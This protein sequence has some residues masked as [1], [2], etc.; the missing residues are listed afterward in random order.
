VRR[1]GGPTT[2]GRALFVLLALGIT[3]LIIPTT[4]VSMSMPV[5]SP[6]PAVRP[7]TMVTPAPAGADAGQRRT[8]ALARMEA[9]IEWAPSAPVGR[10]NRGRL[11]NGVRL[12][13]EGLHFTT[14]DGPRRTGPNRSWRRWGTGR[15]VSMVL[16]VSRDYAAANPEASRI[17]VGDLSRRYGGDFGRRYGGD[18]HASHQNGLDVDIWYP[19]KDGA[20]VAPTTLASIDRE[21][22]QDLLNRFVAAGAEY[23]FVGDRS[24][25]RAPKGKSEVVRVWPNHNDHMHVRLR[26]K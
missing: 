11:V 19:R 7:S 14:W 18:G 20:E 6:A 13:A 12:P 2:S 10:P 3:G 26:R 22:A 21:L 4:P 8:A 1:V 25:L 15:L 5:R 16:T 9:A 17:L 24:G 23:V